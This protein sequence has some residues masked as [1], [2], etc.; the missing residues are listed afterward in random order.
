MSLLLINE[1]PLQVL[2]SLAVKIGLAEA[3]IVQQIH[4]WLQRAKP[5]DDGLCWVYNSVSEWEKQFPFWHKNTIANNL[6]NLREQGILICENKSP[7]AMDRTLYYRIDYEK[8]GHPISQKMCNELHK[9]CEITIKTEITKEYIDRFN[10][11]WKQYP[12][13]VAKPYA[14]KVWKKINPSDELLQKMLAAI[15]TQ[16]LRNKDIQFVPNPATWLNGERWEDEVT[17]NKVAEF[18]IFRRAK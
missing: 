9:N 4:Y 2:P 12:K 10:V 15:N 8:L 1:P 7:K 5:M 18:D 3:I 13:K 16:G 11:F 14:L 17:N 6:K